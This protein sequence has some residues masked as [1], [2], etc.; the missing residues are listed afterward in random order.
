MSTGSQRASTTALLFPGQ[1]SQFQGMVEA[2]EK[3]PPAM[4]L[5]QEASRVLGYDLLG[6]L[7]EADSR[8]FSDTAFVQPA[9][10]VTSLALLTASGCLDGDA[11]FLSIHSDPPVAEISETADG[12]SFGSAAGHSL[13]EYTALV[14]SKMVTFAEG[15]ELVATRG[16][17]MKM[18]CA[19]TK[20]AMV[21]L[22]G[23]EEKRVEEVCAERRSRG[24]AVWVANLNC[25]GQVV[26]SGDIAEVEQALANPRHFGARRAVMLDVAGACHTPLMEPALKLLSDAVSKVDFKSS[27]VT[28]WSNVT[29]QPYASPEEVPKLLARQL[30]EPVRWKQTLQN[31]ETAGVSAFVCFGP[32]DTMAGLARR[33]LLA[34]NKERTGNAA[35]IVR[36]ETF[37]SASN[38]TVETVDG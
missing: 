23:A 19:M 16:E 3:C 28:V 10:F 20:G 7:R 18:A 37:A 1:G 11:N 32:S 29:A 25:P 8:S 6:A 31:L 30:V 33:C 35:R 5:F 27:P 13:G 9:I 15:L 17:A 4:D 2:V 24:G 38:P 12:F 14:A 21:A 34:N 22:L 26:I 36:I